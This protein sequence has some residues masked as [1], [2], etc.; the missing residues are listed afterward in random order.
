MRFGVVMGFYFI[1]IIRLFY[2]SISLFFM[3]YFYLL[4]F[5]FLYSFLSLFYILFCFMIRQRQED[6]T[7][8]V[9]L[10]VLLV[11]FRL[12]GHVAARR[13]AAWPP[14]GGKIEPRARVP[15]DARIRTPDLGAV[16]LFLFLRDFTADLLLVDALLFHLLLVHLLLLLF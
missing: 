8:A 14:A 7:E 9:H 16:G 11:E 1:Y 5:C 3:R 12:V 15:N 4:Y 6:Q 10:Q 13:H 2:S